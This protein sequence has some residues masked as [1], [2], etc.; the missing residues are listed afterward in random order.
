MQKGREKKEREE[1]VLKGGNRERMYKMLI[2]VIRQAFK[3]FLKQEL[4]TFLTYIWY[5][6]DFWADEQTRIRP[7]VKKLRLTS[8]KIGN[9][10][11]VVTSLV[12]KCCRLAVKRRE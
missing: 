6:R 1:R 10:L 7:W 9:P 5:L 3:Y 4:K 11:R 8:G 12:M 2:F